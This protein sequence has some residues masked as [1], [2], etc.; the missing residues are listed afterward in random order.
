MNPSV[1]EE[2]WREKFLLRFRNISLF[3]MIDRAD[4]HVYK[5]LSHFRLDTATTVHN[6]AIFYGG[7]LIS[8]ILHEPISNIF[9]Q[10]IVLMLIRLV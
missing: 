1:E 5:S 10:N 8:W 4:R 7:M 2:P 3:N 9:L 6:V